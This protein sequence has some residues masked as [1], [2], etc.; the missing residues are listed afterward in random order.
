MCYMMVVLISKQALGKSIG[1][2]NT[3]ITPPVDTLQEAQVF[4]TGI[5]AEL[6]HSAGGAYSLTT[7]SGTNELHFSAEERYIH[8]DWLHRQKFN[9]GATNTPVEY[10]H[11]NNTLS[12]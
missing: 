12:G 8:K 3:A 11:F 10:H 9:Q 6:G 7:K 2:V 5:P 1:E 4:T